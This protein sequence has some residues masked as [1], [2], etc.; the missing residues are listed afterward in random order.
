[1]ATVYKAICLADAVDMVVDAVISQT[2]ADLPLVLSLCILWLTN[3]YM[4]S[5][6]SHHAWPMLQDNKSV[7]VGLT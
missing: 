6:T 3:M 5:A 1:M 2:L 4:K 7:M